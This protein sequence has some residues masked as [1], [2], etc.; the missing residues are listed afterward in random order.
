MCIVKSN[1]EKLQPIMV[2]HNYEDWR[3]IMNLVREAVSTHENW[4]NL[5]IQNKLLQ[6][7][8]GLVPPL[9]GITQFASKYKY[10]KKIYRFVELVFICLIREQYFIYLAV[11]ADKHYIDFFQLLL[12]KTPR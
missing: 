8:F 6:D 12:H 10:L 7:T 3:S 2:P 1:G 9:K 11:S 5:Y 4:F